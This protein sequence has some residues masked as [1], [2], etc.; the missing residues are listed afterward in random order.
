M[1]NWSGGKT[2]ALDN[3]R[4]NSP[5]E[6]DS[7]VVSISTC[8][9]AAQESITT[10][11]NPDRVRGNPATNG[12]RVYRTQEDKDAGLASTTCG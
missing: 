10:E 9:T 12:Q 1:P 7:V 11:I 8:H 5:S 6:L 3:V 4:E 2:N